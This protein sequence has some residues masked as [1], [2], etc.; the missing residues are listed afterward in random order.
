MSWPTLSFVR[1]GE[2]EK[3]GTQRFDIERERERK[4]GDLGNDGC[5]PEIETETKSELEMILCFFEG[6][7]RRK[8]AAGE[9]PDGKDVLSYFLTK[10]E[11]GSLASVFR[12]FFTSHLSQN[13]QI[14]QMMTN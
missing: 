14:S 13:F 1:H 7:R 8:I 3:D 4:R 6:E 5:Y 9:T 12:I 2:N 10:D 11:N